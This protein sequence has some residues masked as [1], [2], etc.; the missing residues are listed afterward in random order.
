MG[1]VV[2]KKK[3]IA[4]ELQRWRENKCMPLFGGDHFSNYDSRQIM[5]IQREGIG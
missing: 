3:E 4:R 1:F 5:N 2:K